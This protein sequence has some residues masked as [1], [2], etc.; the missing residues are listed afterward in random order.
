MLIS[1]AY[2][3]LIL[4]ASEKPETQLKPRVFDTGIRGNVYHI[5]LDEMQTDAAKIFLQEYYKYDHLPGFILFDNN[6]SNYL[7]TE[8]SLPSYMTGSLYAGGDFED[9]KESFKNRGI[10]KA[11]STAGYNCIFFSARRSWCNKYVSECYSLEDIYEKYSGEKYSHIKDFV[12]I[13]FARIMP[14]ALTNEALDIGRKI[15]KFVFDLTRSASITVPHSISEGKEPFSSRLLLKEVLKTEDN[16]PASG[17]YVYVHAILPHGPYVLDENGDY[18]PNLR[19][20]GT[21]AYYGQV[22]CAFKLIFEFIEKLKRLGRYDDATIVI[23]A[24]TGHGHRGFIRKNGSRLIATVDLQDTDHKVSIFNNKDNWSEKQLIARTMALLMI[25]TQ[26]DRRP[27]RF[28]SRKSQLIDLYPTLIDLLNLKNTDEK[29]DG[30]SLFSQEFPVNREANFFFYHPQDD[31][32]EFLK[33]RISDQTNVDGSPISVLGYIEKYPTVDL[34]R[35]MI[36][37]NIGSKKDNRLKLIGFHNREKK[38]KKSFHWRWA[39]KKESTIIFRGYRLKKPTTLLVAFNVNPFVVNHNKP[40]VLKTSLSRAEVILKPGW[41][42]YEVTLDFPSGKHPR[43]DIF[44]KSHE[45]PAALGISNDTRNLS[46]AWSQ[47]SIKPL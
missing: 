18:H 27:F 17:Q 26:N 9:W 33:I 23:Q 36:T 14:N 1:A 34:P 31:N 39:I 45:S 35:K 42:R 43:L 2:F 6:I 41:N 12:Q 22:Q 16:R 46:V 4:I 32:P 3:A 44:Y 37:F 47:I 30:L 38:I 25:K 5:V 28:S 7:Y 29:I 24:D 20:E 15:G 21:A 13:W 10:L 8:A 11:L 40:M 19:E